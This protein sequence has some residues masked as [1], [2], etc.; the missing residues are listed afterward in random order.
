M[1][2]SNVFDDKP[3]FLSTYGL[4]T[5]LLDPSTSSLEKSTVIFQPFHL[6]F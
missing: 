6:A 2:G 3:R 5:N 4:C 1:G